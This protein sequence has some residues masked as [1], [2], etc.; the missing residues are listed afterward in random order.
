MKTGV[1]LGIIGAIAGIWF[2]TREAGGGRTQCQEIS[3]S[4]WYYFTYVGKRKT[5]M[6]ALGDCFDVIYTIDVWNGYEYDPPADPMNDI[7]EPGSQC[8][9]MV[10]APC[11]LCNFE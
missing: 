11:R 10:Q 1:V 3:P 2:L 8:R 5:F 6:A 4:Q 9:V 7:I